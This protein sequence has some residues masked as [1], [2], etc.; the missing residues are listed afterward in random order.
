MANSWQGE[1]PNENLEL[2]GFD[3]TAPV[4]SFPPNGYGLF[5]MAGNVW[6]WTTDW[7]R[8]HGRI[9]DACCTVDATRAAAS[10]TPASTRTRPA[11]GSRGR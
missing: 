7:Y 6:E 11:R 4:G 3:G 5:D 1:F 9:E 10:A 2:D 8:E